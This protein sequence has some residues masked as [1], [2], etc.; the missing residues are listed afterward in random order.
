MGDIGE[1][2]MEKWKV[3]LSSEAEDQLAKIYETNQDL[4]PDILARLKILE[5]FP[6]EKWFFVYKHKG[7]DLFRAETG[8]MLRISGEAHFSTKTVQITHVKL[9]R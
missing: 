4:R 9:V 5:N 6:P 2:N 8:Q 1:G 7:L 3:S